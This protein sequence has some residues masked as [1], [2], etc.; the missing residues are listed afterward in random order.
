MKSHYLLENPKDLN[1]IIN[2]NCHNFKYITMENQQE[3]KS[4][5]I[6]RVGSSEK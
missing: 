3:T 2:K 1:T 6:M 5:K 4:Y